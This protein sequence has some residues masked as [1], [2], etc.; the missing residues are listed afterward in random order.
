MACKSE[1]RISMSNRV[2]IGD[3]AIEVSPNH[4]YLD[5]NLPKSYDYVPWN[6]IAQILNEIGYSSSSLIDL[7]QTS[8]TRLRT[9]AVI[10]WPPRCV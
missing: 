7:V 3:F 10:R 8:A 4:I 2:S 5:P 9:F 6:V 1:M